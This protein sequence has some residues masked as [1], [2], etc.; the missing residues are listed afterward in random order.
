MPTEA[1]LNVKRRMT[2][3]WPPAASQVT[4]RFRIGIPACKSTTYT[5]NWLRSAKCL[6]TRKRLHPGHEN[7]GP[8]AVRRN[9]TLL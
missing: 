4:S 5:E 9:P 1:Q 7:L 8:P 6:C 2:L 3:K